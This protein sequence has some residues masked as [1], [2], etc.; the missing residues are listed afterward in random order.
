MLISVTDDQSEGDG[1]RWRVNHG[2]EATEL[3]SSKEV[4]VERVF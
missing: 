4:A 1:I 2:P 3:V